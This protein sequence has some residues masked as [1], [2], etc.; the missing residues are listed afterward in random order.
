MSIVVK[1]NLAQSVKQKKNTSI[2]HKPFDKIN[3]IL[4]LLK[5]LTNSYT[6]PVDA[7]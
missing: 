7:L 3:E 6:Y 1:P 4:I 2:P 5:H